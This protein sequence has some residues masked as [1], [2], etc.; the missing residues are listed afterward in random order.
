MT[1]FPGAVWRPM[2]GQASRPRRRKGRGVGFHIAVTEAPSIY[3]INLSTGNDA[4]LYVRRDGGVEQNVDLDVQAWAGRDGNPSMVWV[5]TQG[6][7]TPADVKTGRWTGPQAETLARIAAFLHD[8]EGTP[9]DLM[10]NA[11][12]TSRGIATHRLGIKHSAGLVPGWWFPGCELW[13]GAIGK[14]CPGDARV[15][16][17]PEIANRARQMAGTVSGDDMTPQESA[18]LAA[19][20]ENVN[21]IRSYLGVLKASIDAVAAAVAQLQA[22]GAGSVDVKAVAEQLTVVPK[23]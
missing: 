12:P 11:L 18:Q 9:L 15:A 17:L 13:S 16:Q 22:G 4:H 10:P 5:E 1:I 23:S 14:E 6:G 7:T 19:T 3:P 21:Q 20:N 8:T 2:P